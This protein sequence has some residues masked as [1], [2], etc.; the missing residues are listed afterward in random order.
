LQNSLEHL[1]QTQ[2]GLREY[3]ASGDSD[4]EVAKAL[5]ENEGVMCVS[6]STTMAG[7]LDLVLHVPC[8]GSQEERIS[9]LKMAL[10]EKGVHAGSHYD[11]K[12][13][14]PSTPGSAATTA[15]TTSS[16]DE[17]SNEED[18]GIHL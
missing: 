3:L 16:L 12:S 11:L 5:E 17:E 14:P 8:S 18:G 10:S 4:P 15:T 6:S 1:R 7:A 2:E 13:D 9:I